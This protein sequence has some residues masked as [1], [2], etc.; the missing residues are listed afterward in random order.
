ML[1]G[2]SIGKVIT[3][4]GS[5]LPYLSDPEIDYVLEAKNKR[6][7]LM[8]AENVQ[9]APLQ[10]AVELGIA[11]EKEIAAYNEWRKYR[12]TLMRINTSA[13]PNIVWPK[14]PK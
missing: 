8:D 13:A 9:V 12:V 5:D 7:E 11:T 2:Q 3:P 4:N 6:T 1:S 10:D 14:P